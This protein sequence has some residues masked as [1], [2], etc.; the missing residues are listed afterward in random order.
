LITFWAV[1]PMAAAVIEWWDAARK[2]RL[3]GVS[4]ILIEHNTTV[5]RL[6][7]VRYLT[8]VAVEWL[9]QSRC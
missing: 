2:H 4:I 7:Y 8:V 3:W 5:N 6:R 9:V 1:H